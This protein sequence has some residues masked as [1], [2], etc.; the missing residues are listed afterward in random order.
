M[1]VNNQ[2]MISSKFYH[3]CPPVGASIALTK[4]RATWQNGLKDNGVPSIG[5]LRSREIS[6]NYRHRNYASQEDLSINETK[7]TFGGNY[8]F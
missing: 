2:A 7:I 4:T 5:G 6:C 3:L 1:E 8:W